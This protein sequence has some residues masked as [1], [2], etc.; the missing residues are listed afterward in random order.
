MDIKQ[1]IESMAR[2]VNKVLEPMR[3]DVKA[4]GARVAALEAANAEKAYFGVYDGDSGYRKHNMVTHGG[5]M[6]V[7]LEDAPAGTRP[8]ESDEWQL[9]VK[10]GRDAR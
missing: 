7:A 2:V 5:S 8:G 6:W 1:M 3:A 4:L 9:A 10:K